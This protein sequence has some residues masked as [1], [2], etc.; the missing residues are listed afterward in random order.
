MTALG[1]WNF[2]QTEIKIL[3]SRTSFKTGFISFQD[4]P[5][6]SDPTPAARPSPS[7]CS[8]TGR[9]CLEIPRRPPASPTKSSW[10]PGSERVSRT[11]SPTWPITSTSCNETNVNNPPSIEL[12]FAFT[13]TSLVFFVSLLFFLSRLENQSD[14]VFLSFA[15][16]PV[17]G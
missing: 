8:T 14:N 1:V 15:F 7:A 9:S 10:T 17:G 3:S 5:L 12:S 6:T 2:N 4:S 13:L 11:P 16:L